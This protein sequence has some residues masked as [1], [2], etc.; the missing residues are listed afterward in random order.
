M[1]CTPAA[2][3][4]GSTVASGLRLIALAVCAA[5]L[6]FRLATAQSY[7]EDSL[8]VL[9]ILNVNGVD[10]ILVCYPEGPWD[11]LRQ[12]MVG[13]SVE[14]LSVARD[15]RI[16]TLNLDDQLMLGNTRPPVLPP[17]IGVLTALEELSLETNRLDSLPDELA[18][19]QN[20]KRLGLMGSRFSDMPAVL[21]SLPSLEHLDLSSSTLTSL[22]ESVS[23]L[24][25]LV[26]LDLRGNRELR[27]L[28]DGI[29]MLPSL[30]MLLLSAS[31]LQALPHSVGGLVNLRILDAHNCAFTS[32]PD[33]LFSLS[34]LEYLSV[35]TN[36]LVAL[37][38]SMDSLAS[39]TYLDV[40][41]NQLTSLPASLGK[42]ESLGYFNATAN[43]LTVLP[44][45]LG[46]LAQLHTCRVNENNLIGLP[47]TIGGCAR[48]RDL[49]VSDNAISDLP[50]GIVALDSL[51]IYLER[52]RICAVDDEIAA[53]LDGGHTFGDWRDS[54][55][56]SSAVTLPSQHELAPFMRPNGP[57][58]FSFVLHRPAED[59]FLSAYGLDG[60]RV[61]QRPLGDMGAGHH[62]V[63]IAPPSP[64]LC[65]VQVETGHGAQRCVVASAPLY[66]SMGR[67]AH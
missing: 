32:L 63:E 12:C 55:S 31:P 47:S 27:V 30:E 41:S 24:T 4:S 28:P 62:T 2:V 21:L 61:W 38:A 25:A 22:T 49:R 34:T 48:L 5:L 10:S 50:P 9:E 59:L 33:E 56:C 14:S 20:L 64:C 43:A 65:V 42:A 39:L 7:A 53:Y 8:A 23:S 26:E 46:D 18:N 19:L 58:S 17:A 60:R 16:V 54:Q 15:G 51:F 35:R 1:V 57:S 66:P 37:P 40:A 52:N 67:R 13:I 45:S 36:E 11:T 29:G 6:L 3:R 44:E